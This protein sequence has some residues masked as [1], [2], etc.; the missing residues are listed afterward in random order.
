MTRERGSPAAQPD[1]AEAVRDGIVIFDATGRVRLANASARTIT[2]WSSPADLAQ[3]LTFT[4]GLVELRPGKWIELRFSDVTYEED[5]CRAAVFSDVTA[6]VELGEAHRKL[7]E[8]GLVDPVT[9]LVTAP[10]LEDHLRR[11]LALAARDERWVGVLWLDLMR[12]KRTTADGPQVANEVLRQTAG[13]LVALIRPSDLAAR[14]D[15]EAFAVVLTA[16]GGPGDAKVVAVRLVLALAPPVLVMGRER[17]VQ[18]H[19]GASTASD[20]TIDPAV[21]LKRARDAAVETAKGDLAVGRVR[22]P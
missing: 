14:V 1:L 6:Q 17:S 21:L 2:S 22:E 9:R 13:R 20:R 11:S 15:D 16:I 5:P 8:I 3:L 10:V 12:F 18:I 19:I 4:A 7:R